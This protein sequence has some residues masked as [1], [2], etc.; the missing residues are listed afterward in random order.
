MV[1]G[2]LGILDE[3]KLFLHPQALDRTDASGANCRSREVLWAEF[4]MNKDHFLS[5]LRD[6]LTPFQLQKCR[7]RQFSMRKAMGFS[8]E[9]QKLLVAW[10][11]VKPQR[12]GRCR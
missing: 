1:T 9:A 3:G 11:Q 10:N 2:Y 4:W 8:G 7:H 5:F 12:D 6:L